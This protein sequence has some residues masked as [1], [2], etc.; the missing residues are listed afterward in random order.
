MPGLNI[1]EGRLLCPVPITG[2]TSKIRVKRRRD[3]FGTPI[4][5]KSNPFTKDDYL[6]WQISY[7]L[8]LDAIWHAYRKA[9]SLDIFDRLFMVYK[10]QELILPLK[11]AVGHKAPNRK[12]EFVE[13]TRRI[14]QEKGETLITKPHKGNRQYVS[15]ELADMFK[16]ALQEGLASTED[17]KRLLGFNE[18][19]EFD[20]EGQYEI[21]RCS[22]QKLAHDKFEHYEEKTPLFINVISDKTFVEIILKHKQKAVGYQSMIY[23]CTY[24]DN[25]LDH[26]RRPV[27]GRRAQ[28]SEI[29][30]VPVTRDDLLAIAESFIVAS[31]DHAW[32]MKSVLGAIIEGSP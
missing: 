5:I 22:T 9:G 2:A 6:E 29:M 26:E 16:F 7:F 30:H 18:N 31:Q 14:F 1:H 10:G 4:S 25:V 8:A 11:E 17:I 28:P 20:I 24:A 15:Y 32:D 27:I 3:N 21:I 19:R 23:F 12:Q 13:T